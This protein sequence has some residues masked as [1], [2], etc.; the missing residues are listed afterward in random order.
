VITVM[1]VAKLANAW[2]SDEAS[3]E[4]D[5]CEAT[6]ETGEEGIAREDNEWALRRAFATKR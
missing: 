4:G 3:Y 6:G 2:R 1:P 5:A